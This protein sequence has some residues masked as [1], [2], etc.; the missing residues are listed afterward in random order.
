LPVERELQLAVKRRKDA[1][2]VLDGIARTD[3]GEVQSL[4][5]IDA[6]CVSDSV[7]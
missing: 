6:I 3:E 5:R 4:Q 1:G 7:V 2:V